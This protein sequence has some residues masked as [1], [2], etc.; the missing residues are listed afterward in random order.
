M[1]LRIALRYHRQLLPWARL[2][3]LKRK[4]HDPFDSDACKNGDFGR[5]GMGRMAV[6]SASV[7]GV[8]AFAILPHDDPVE[9]V[10]AAFCKRRSNTPQDTGRTDVDVLVKRI[11]DGKDEAPERDV[12]GD[13]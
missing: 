5:D 3:R 12:I 7:A 13:I 10:R 1:P 6:R 8:F 11:A 9:I 2:C 4:S